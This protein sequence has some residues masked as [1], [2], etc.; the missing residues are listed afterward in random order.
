MLRY[1]VVPLLFCCC[2]PLR[3]IHKVSSLTSGLSSVILVTS[4][5]C[6]QVM[7]L[8]DLIHAEG[9]CIWY[10][11]CKETAEG[12]WLNCYNNTVKVRVEDYSETYYALKSVCPWY[13]DKQLN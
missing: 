5:H 7:G 10:G 8:N 13:I 12:K 6:F 1:L 11:Q 9:R 4:S 2:L 3:T